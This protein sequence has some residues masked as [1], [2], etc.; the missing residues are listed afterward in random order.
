MSVR[1][2]LAQINCRVGDI[3]GNTKN[4]VGFIKKAADL[5]ADIVVLPE[6]AITGYPPEDLLLRRGFVKDNLNALD[7]VRR[8]SRSIITIVGFVESDDNIYNSAAIIQDA[9]IADIYR[10]SRLPNYGVFD[11]NRYFRAG[12]SVSVY[13]LGS[14]I[15]GVNICEDVWYIGNPTK[16]QV[17][18]GKA[19]LI[20]NLSSSPYHLNKPEL[21]EKMLIRR[22]VDNGC[23]IA[24][25]NLVGGQD[26]LVFDGDSCVISQNGEVISRAPQFQ[27]DLLVSDIDITGVLNDEKRLV[28]GK[29]IR[30]I[31]LASRRR[32]MK[33]AV[34]PKKVEF[35]IEEEE[36]FNALVLGTRDYVI[37]NGFKKVV[38][39]LSGGIDSS[40]VAVIAKESIGAG[41]VLGILMPSE[42]SSKGSVEDSLA[43]AENLGIKTKTVPIQDI[44]SS[45]LKSLNPHF[46]DKPQNEAEE[47]IQARIRGNILMAFSNK[48]GYMVL[49]TGNKSEMSVGYSTLYGDMAGGFAVIKDV[50]KTFVYKLAKFYN[51]IQKYNVIPISVIE[52]QPSAELRPDQKDTDF[53]PPYEELDRILK[54]CIEDDLS[55]REIIDKGEDEITVE[56]VVKMV[57]QNEYKRRQSPPGIKI[58]SRAFGKDR[59]MPITSGYK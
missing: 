48:F 11:E 8:A 41:N 2:A 51:T 30:S 58:T 6:M 24:F 56:R 13:R 28:S 31:K 46:R 16:K 1:I 38:I 4:I 43:L 15:F 7:N 29:E 3:K 49:T 55:I 33:K 39:G 45:Y 12:N 35:K 36:I 25:C 20:I 53:L 44:F 14:L 52:K 47:N 37:K 10:K 40:L 5:D 18:V 22:A 32:K 19:Q 21:R 57:Y 42:Y 23:C 54:Y 17:K 59:R 50:P 9:K 34:L 26:E 27:E